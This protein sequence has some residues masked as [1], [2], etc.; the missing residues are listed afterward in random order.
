MVS[1]QR[2]RGKIRLY[3]N[4]SLL[5]DRRLLA[6]STLFSPTWYLANYPDVA[7]SD[8]DPLDHYLLRGAS[9]GR[10]PS[11]EFDPDFYLASN[12]EIAGDGP[13]ALVHY[14]RHGKQ[15]GRIAQSF[16]VEIDFVRRSGLFDDAWYAATYP[17]VAASGL[18]PIKHYFAYGAKT[19]YSPGPLFDAA[20]FLKRYADSGAS[21]K[22]ALLWFLRA[23]P[24]DV[25]F[26]QS[27]YAE[28]VEDRWGPSSSIRI[29]REHRSEPTIA[30]CVHVFYLDVFEEICDCL[31]NLPYR[32]TLLITTPVEAYIDEIR[33]I[34]ESRQLPT[35][36]V[37]RLSQNRGRNFAPFL[38]EF[39]D[40]IQ[41]HE[42]ML[43]LHTKKS[44]HN[45]PESAKWRANLFK[46][47]LASRYLVNSII[48]QF[49]QQ[50]LG[51]FYPATYAWLPYWAHHWL[52][53][54]HLIQ[55]FY[56]RVGV[57]YSRPIEYVNFPVGSMFWART[58][59]LKPLFDA[60][61]KYEDFPAEAGQNDGTIAHVIERSLVTIATSQGFGFTEFDY[62]AGSLR[63]NW[64][65]KNL[66]QY[67]SRTNEQL[68]AAIRDA[69][70]V[71]F[72]IFDTLITRKTLTPD[73][74]FHYVGWL[75]EKRE[76]GL[77][78]FF[79]VRK[80]SENAARRR[81]N[82]EGDVDLDEIYAEFPNNDGWSVETAI[83][84]KQLEV[85]YESRSFCKR[86]DVAAALAYAH[87]LNKRIIAVSDTYFQR[88]FVEHLLESLG[89]LN[90]IAEL[91]LSSERGARKDHGTMWDL[92]ITA[93]N[94]GPKR[95]LHIG[96]NEHSDAQLAG[97]RK[98]DLFHVM[99]PATLMA[100]SGF[101]IPADRHWSFDLVLGPIAARSFNSPFLSNQQFRPIHVSGAKNYGYLVFGPLLFGFLSW[102]LAHPA[103]HT[104]DRLYFLSREG[105][106]L[107]RLFERL[108]AFVDVKLPPASYLYTSRR[109]T[110]AAAQ[111]I[112]FNPTQIAFGSG[113]TGTLA[114]LLETR[115]GLR[116]PAHAELNKIE[117]RLPNDAE[118]VAVLL[119][120]LKP[121][122]VAHGKKEIDALKT[123]Y[124]NEGLLD[125]QSIGL[126]DVGYSASIQ[127]ALQ[128]VLG[129]AMTGFYMATSEH[130]S[131]VERDG[132]VALSCFADREPLVHRRSPLITHSQILETFLTAP[133]GQVL[134]F[135][136]QGGTA[137]PVFKQAGFSQSA[138]PKLNEIYSGV[139][140]YFDD[141][142]TA[143][144]PQAFLAPIDLNA[145]Q[146]PYA[147]FATHHIVLSSEITEALFLE[148]EYCGNPDAK[149]AT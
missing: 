111:A 135:Q 100:H 40:L 84:A 99:S 4:P 14:L 76:A 120:D 54:T 42:L 107:F 104:L 50:D 60:H 25:M 113:F 131:R 90:F 87:S 55:A 7:R 88:A 93:E 46:S 17:D 59:A 74:L 33:K 122:I 128:K 16:A 116:P 6:S 64:S 92:V 132:G 91:Y 21:G 119:A 43:H 36:P 140:A 38:V 23:Q 48:D 71:S 115:L 69:D 31:K 79:S 49:Q 94:A 72:D 3:T 144:G 45:G 136:M 106:F 123:Y 83:L 124:R 145:A 20:E 108:R 15:Q 8:I 12:P 22:N 2:L 1:F 85:E 39:S 138:F 44:L 18:Q 10:A 149:L 41:Q 126:V 143:F 148:D 127:D 129:T 9:E 11:E 101:K 73:S 5:R 29:S 61:W 112:E 57:A 32:F 65:R 62:Q 68:H 37:T 103:L 63:Y 27:V 146:L 34:V 28:R 105:Y 98:L 52:S 82:F 130:A 133:Q 70:I 56:E 121:M 24:S 67:S 110:I 58:R 114:D 86:N 89:L 75:L 77:N 141:V 102:L 97:D 78:D 19:G 125:S 109:A 35:K 26:V 117:I 118:D 147:A 13:N 96:D 51:L 66:Y 47:L 81:K 95:L 137:T 142:L 53:N 139:E 80:N 134:S 30:V